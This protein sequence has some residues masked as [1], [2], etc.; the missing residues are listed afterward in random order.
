[1]TPLLSG[2]RACFGGHLGARARLTRQGSTNVALY[3]PVI[4]DCALWSEVQVGSPVHAH[5]LC[6]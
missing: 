1:M 4:K 6:I 5:P 3:A 2:E